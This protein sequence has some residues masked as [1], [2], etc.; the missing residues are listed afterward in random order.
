[1]SV[2]SN[3]IASQQN[4]KKL[5]ISKFFCLQLVSL[6]P[7]INHCFRMS[8]RIFVKIRNDPKGILR[9]RGKLIHE[10]SQGVENLVSD[11]L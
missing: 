7:V 5:P 1:M 11:S 6:T 10:K 4:K 8:P 9:A 2:K 3:P